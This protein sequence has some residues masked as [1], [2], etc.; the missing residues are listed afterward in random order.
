MTSEL[1]LACS[2]HGAEAR[3]RLVQ[4]AAVGEAGLLAVEADTAGA[5]LRFRPEVRERLDAIVA[6]EA[7]CCPFLSLDLAEEPG[8]LRLTISAPADAEPV[9]HDLVAAFRGSSAK[10]PRL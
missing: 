10:G 3:E 8:M 2:L 6:A 9:L 1:P 5:T 7:E 4:I